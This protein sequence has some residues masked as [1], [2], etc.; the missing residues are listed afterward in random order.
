MK[1]DH[2]MQIP[3]QTISGLQA[4]IAAVVRNPSSHIALGGAPALHENRKLILDRTPPL[5]RRPT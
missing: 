5:M 1:T 2:C 3:F 4:S